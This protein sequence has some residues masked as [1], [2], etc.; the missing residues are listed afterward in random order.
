MFT[1]II[2]LKELD[3]RTALTRIH[4]GTSMYIL[5]NSAYISVI[6]DMQCVYLISIPE[7]VIYVMYMC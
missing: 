4:T 5:L 7:P 3:I 6:D 1:V 2:I